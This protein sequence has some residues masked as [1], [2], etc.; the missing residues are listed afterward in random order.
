M[1]VF[2]GRGKQEEEGAVQYCEHHPRMVRSSANVNYYNKCSQ[3]QTTCCL[4][5][6]EGKYIHSIIKISKQPT[7]II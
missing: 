4:C 6:E 7:K 1:D 5:F 3:L 2:G